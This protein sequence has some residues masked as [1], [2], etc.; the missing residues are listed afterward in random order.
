MKEFKVYCPFCNNEYNKNEL[1]FQ[2]SCGKPLSIAYSFDQ[3]SSFITNKKINSIWRYIFLLPVDIDITNAVSFGEG[4]TPLLREVYKDKTCFI[5]LESINPSGSFKDRGASILIS[6]LKSI[7]VKEF[8]EDSS[9]NAG[10]AYAMYAARAN[11]TAH[12]YVPHYLNENR[13]FHLNL[14]NAKVHVISGTRKDV[15]DAALIASEKIYYASHAWNPFFLHGV[16]TIVYEICEQFNSDS[17][18]PI[19]ISTGNG[20]LLL[21]IFLGLKDLFNLK[22]INKIP[23][24]FAI[25]PANCAPLKYFKEH[26]SLEG[27]TPGYSVA[28]GTLIGNPPRLTEM[29]NA[30]EE[31]KGDIIAISDESILNAFRMLNSKGYFVEPTSSLA[32][33]AFMEKPLDNGIVILTG[34]AL[35]INKSDKY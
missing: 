17:L 9:G 7:G 16:K 6:Y 27:F 2:C 8:I 10:L 15:S 28:E 21:G 13:L 34:S 23:P 22:L 4:F 35:K 29:I 33:A 24:L 26:R 19:Y 12:I 18:P 20:T 1:L 30:I 3:N 25:Q 5:K 14:L 11:L 32:F 31:T